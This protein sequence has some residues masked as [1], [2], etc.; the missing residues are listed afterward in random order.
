MLSYRIVLSY[1]SVTCSCSASD[2]LYFLIPMILMPLY[3]L[4][5]AWY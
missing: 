1:W 4:F 2:H 3:L 5:L